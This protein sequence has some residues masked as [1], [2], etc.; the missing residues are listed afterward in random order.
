MPLSFTIDNTAQDPSN[1]V[2]TDFYYNAQGPYTHDELITAYMS[3]SLTK[4]ILPAEHLK[5]IQ[6]SAFPMRRPELGSRAYADIP[7]PTM[8]MPAGPR[9]DVDG[10]Y[11]IA[12]YSIPAHVTVPVPL[13]CLRRTTTNPGLTLPPLPSRASAGPLAGWVGISTPATPSEPAP[14]STT[15]H[16]RVSP[17][18][19]KSR[20]TRSGSSTQLTTLSPGTF[21]SS[22]CGAPLLLPQPPRRHKRRR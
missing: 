10:R 1:W 7:G 15:S 5:T 19:T 3:D 21:F 16:S 18:P 11:V 22:M 14:I 9:Y 8:Y 12:I 4:V 13:F 6:K 20:S 2:A 17:L